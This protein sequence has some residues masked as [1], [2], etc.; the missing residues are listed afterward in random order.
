GNGFYVNRHRELADKNAFGQV[1]APTQQQFGGGVGFPLQ[2]DRL[3]FFGA[4]EQQIFRNERAV[5][6]NLTGIPR[7]TD[8]AEAFDFYRSLE[9]DFEAT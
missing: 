2:R 8:N 7:S 4:Y 3:F 6:F 5:A 1:A 9:E